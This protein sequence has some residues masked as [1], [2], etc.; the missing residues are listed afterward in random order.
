MTL[1]ID[2]HG[3]EVLVLPHPPVRLQ[4]GVA[5]SSQIYWRIM[6]AL[7]NHK[8]TFIGGNHEVSRSDRAVIAIQCIS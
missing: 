2:W 1:E 5:G 8:G 7:S 3:Y 4:A 6:P